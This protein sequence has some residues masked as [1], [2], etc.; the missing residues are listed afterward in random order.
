M[1]AE[2]TGHALEMPRADATQNTDGQITVS[3]SFEASE[4]DKYVSG[5]A[6][7]SAYH[8][9][10]FRD[11][12]T[13]SFGRQTHYLIAK[14]E[15]RVV[16]VLP[17]VRLKSVLFGDFM[18]SLPYVTNGGA[19]A[20]GM[21]ER[22]A[23]VKASIARSQELGCSHLELRDME[24][25]EGMAVRT[26][27]VTM[28]LPLPD[29]AEEL[30][31]KIGSKL[32]AQVRRPRKAGAESVIGGVELLDDFY[33]VVSRKY[34]DLGVPI[35][36]RKWFQS[37]LEWQP[38]NARIA[39]VKLDGKIVAAGL[40]IGHGDVVEVPY[41]ASLREADRLSVNMLL[42]WAMMEHAIENGFKV[43]DFGR[44]TPN[45]GTHR[46]KR[47]WGAEQVQLYWHYWMAD[48]GE[49]PQLNADNGKY[50][51]AVSVWRKLPLWVTNMVGPQ[52]VKNLP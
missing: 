51:M 37:L 28:H 39:A 34:R 8:L 30:F 16:G 9:I 33:A 13:Q 7:G 23:L 17:L 4:W 32:R 38:E 20:D 12:I 31:S 35:Y 6:S 22:D 15:Q 43:F 47:Q 29:D 14:R 11:A 21:E 3:D 40:L 5:H 36:S 19:L 24:P 26:D 46:F 41:A 50:G 18:V 42:Y 52:I 1:A 48:G 10:G 27:R 49:M 44:T 25:M 45:S 2:P